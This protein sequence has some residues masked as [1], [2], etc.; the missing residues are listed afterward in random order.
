MRE[1]RGIE[2]AQLHDRVA[3]KDIL[4]SDP[5]KLAHERAVLAAKIKE[6]NQNEAKEILDY[7][8]EEL[9]NTK[10][11]AMVHRVSTETKIVSEIEDTIKLDNLLK[12]PEDRLFAVPVEF[13]LGKSDPV[14]R[15]GGADGLYDSI[16]NKIKISE[17]IP[18]RKELWSMMI[19]SGTPEIIRILDH[20]L[21]HYWEHVGMPLGEKVIDKFKRQKSTTPR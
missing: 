6:F 8:P 13:G 1:N 3:R 21:I 17:D 2:E 20:E 4:D 12:N 14:F 19:Q 7:L 15:H 16:N 18:T 10:F 9:V 11:Q 5:S